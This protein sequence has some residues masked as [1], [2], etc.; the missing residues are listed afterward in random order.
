MI[1]NEVE[2]EIDSCVYTVNYLLDENRLY[3]YYEGE[4]KGQTQVNGISPVS[5][6][7]TF[8]KAFLNKRAL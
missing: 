4:E 1:E 6:S 8:M 3:V 7:R 5:A 2:L